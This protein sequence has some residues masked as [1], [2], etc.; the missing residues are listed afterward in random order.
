MSINFT[1]SVDNKIVFLGDTFV[2]KSSI[3]RR[4]SLRD[5]NNYQD[6]TIGAAFTSFNVIKNDIRY[7]YKIWDTAGQE[8]YR[9]L[10]SMY[11]RD[12]DYAVIVF[13]ISQENSFEGVKSWINE[14][15]RNSP[16]SRIII[17][18]NKIDLAIREDKEVIINFL[19]NNSY[20]Y[21]EVSA[22]TGENIDT[23]FDFI[24]ENNIKK[25][26]KVNLNNSKIL[27]DFENKRDRN[28]CFL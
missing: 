12:A 10:A 5:F 18:A 7:N 15:K 9:S 4:F 19:N 26:Q 17:V 11:Y 21:F 8:R 1:K 2:G 14:L 27:L 25:E 13:N 6:P 22:K 16:D 3:V 20:D 23:L 28:C 24:K